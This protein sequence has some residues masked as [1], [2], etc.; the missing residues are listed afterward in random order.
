MKNLSPRQQKI[1]NL[2]TQKGDLTI[3]EIRALTG[4]SQATAYREIHA[5]NQAGVAQKTPGGLALPPASADLCLHCRR[6]VHPRLVFHI[7]LSDGNRRAACC[8]HCGLL[9]LQYLPAT[10]QVMTSDF[11]YG[12]LL[13]AAHAW[14]VLESTIAPCCHPSTFVFDQQANA[15][16][17]AAA[18]GGQVYDFSAAR[19]QI[20]RLMLLH[21][22]A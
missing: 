20:E 12:A 10:R 4:I 1:L 11:L 19:E 6:P 16:R 17:F 3:A 2:L 5:L 9:A 13:N 8:A 15:E 22:T 7:E 18:F 21:R 14:Y